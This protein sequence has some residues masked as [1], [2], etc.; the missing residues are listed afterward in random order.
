MSLMS[1]DLTLADYRRTLEQF[2][3][4]HV[5]VERQIARHF[6]AMGRLGLVWAERRKVPHLERDLAVL[7][8]GDAP[9]LPERADDSLLDLPTFA[10]AMGALY[11]VEGSTLGG[12]VIS[13]N[14]HSVLRI[15][16]D[17]GG[18]F[19][20]G[21]GPETGS[22]WKEFCAAMERALVGPEARDAA[23]DAANATFQLF[24]TCTG[25][26]TR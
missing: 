4:F 24:A 18:A 1:P 9:S 19:F 21:Y 20:H 26:S 7:R 13:R 16:P 10:H 6:L 2:L 22:R 23:V 8:G 3:A 15:G 5:T 25:G 14:V 17:D 11:V 12:V